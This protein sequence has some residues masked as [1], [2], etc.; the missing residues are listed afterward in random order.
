MAEKLGSLKI[1]QRYVFIEFNASSTTIRHETSHERYF[2][3]LTHDDR[4]GA[5]QRITLSSTAVLTGYHV[6]AKLLVCLW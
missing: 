4:R 3:Y 5:R 1:H 2:P 6:Q